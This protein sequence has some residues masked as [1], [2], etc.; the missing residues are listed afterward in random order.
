MN[1]LAYFILL[2]LHLQLTLFTKPTGT[3]NV[4][5]APDQVKLGPQI[6]ALNI[7]HCIHLLKG[8]R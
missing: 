4:A 2:C 1:T 5:G 3:E 7:K 8:R 6:Y